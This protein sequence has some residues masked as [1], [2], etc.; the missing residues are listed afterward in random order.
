MTLRRHF[1]LS[2]NQ[3]GPSPKAIGEV[4]WTCSSSALEDVTRFAESLFFNWLIGGTDAHAKNYSV[5]LSSHGKVRLA[6]L[7][8]LASSLPYPQQIQ[9]RKASMAMKIGSHYQI[10]E[11]S[12]TDWKKFA[13]EL[14][15]SPDGVLEHIR[16]MADRIGGSSEVVAA[17]LTHEGVT[18]PVIGRIVDALK[19][20]VK[21]CVLALDVSR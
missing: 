18:H 9:T 16:H 19:S 21:K 20:H 13:K 6:P 11:I 14:R 5:L 1:S 12:G 4:L 3:G 15:I 10:S 17:A 2:E 7:Y 8:D